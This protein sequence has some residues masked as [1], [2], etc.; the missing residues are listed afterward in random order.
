MT[1]EVL[2]G[3]GLQSTLSAAIDATTGLITIQA[4]DAPDW[5]TSG[6]YRA[7][8]WADP[9]SGPWELVKVTG[10]Q[11]TTTLGVERAAESYRGTQ[12]ARPWPSGT[13]IAAVITQDGITAL[14]QGLGG[15]GLAVQ[16]NEFV[17][18]ASATTVTLSSTPAPGQVFMVARNG[19]VQSAAAGHYTVSSSVITFAAPFSGSERVIASYVPGPAAAVQVNEF[20]PAASAITVTLSAAPVTV[21]M[22][23]RSGVIQSR[24]AGHYSVSGR[25]VTFAASFSGTE[26][27]IVSYST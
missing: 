22:V 20:V 27:V 14:L 2:P 1:L 3:N 18:A 12:Q 25:T 24:A 11:G 7:V 17:P 26:R 5:P 23:A 19:V 8:L 21:F 9:Q 10:G 13:G 4:V 15:G 16:V 6:Q